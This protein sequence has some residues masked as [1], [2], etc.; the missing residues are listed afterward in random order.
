VTEVR[1][2]SWKW[3]FT[4]DGRV[5]R[6]PYF[7]AGSILTVIKY[8][9][10]YFVAAHF[11][12]TWRIWNYVFPASQISIFDLGLRR[13]EMYAILWAIAIPFFWI[14][15][16]LTLRRL[17]DAG[18]RPGWIFLFFVP[19]ANLLLFLWLILAP[20]TE[21]PIT[22]APD[23]G[24][25]RRTEGFRTEI[26]GVLIAVVLG[27]AL[28][29]WGTQVLFVYGW[30][31]FLGVPFLTG[32][33][34]SWFLNLKKIRFVSQ[35]NGRELIR[36]SVHWCCP[37]K[38]RT[39]GARLSADGCPV[40]SSILRRRRI[41]GTFDF[42]TP[43]PYFSGTELRSM[44]GHPAAR[45]VCGARRQI[46]S[47]GDSRNN[48]HYYQLASLGRM[49]E[50]HRLSSTRASQRM[51]VPSWN[52]VSDCRTDCRIGTWSRALLS[53]FDRRFR[54]ANHRVG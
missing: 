45:H 51:V 40:G 31:L 15:I 49:E 25:S 43:Q 33:I 35:H 24:E 36:A 28:A 50:R 53:F 16:A 41:N 19:L 2:G 21:K 14:G 4:W 30:G 5:Q 54:R 1:Q 3:L 37:A 7:L 34:A 13:P 12:E 42:A 26:L 11:G 46:R 6:K 20:T 22:E 52:R 48:Q 10:D 44:C 32:F 38:P 29:V 18:D 8:A 39:G 47:A 9:I 17:R 27:V 23:Q